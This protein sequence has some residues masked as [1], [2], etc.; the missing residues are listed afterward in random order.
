MSFSSSLGL[1]TVAVLVHARTRYRV[2][3]LPTL[4]LLA[5]EVIVASIATAEGPT[6]VLALAAFVLLTGSLSRIRCGRETR[7]DAVGSA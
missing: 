2:A 1:M 3:I 6:L 4:C 7:L 5:G